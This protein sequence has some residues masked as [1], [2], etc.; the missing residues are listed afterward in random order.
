MSLRSSKPA[1][2]TSQSMRKVS[3]G[4][5][6]DEE[7]S[8]LSELMSSEESELENDWEES[9]RRSTGGKKVR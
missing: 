9:Q 3:A 1:K 4:E 5:D 2:A 8:E 6:S 7:E